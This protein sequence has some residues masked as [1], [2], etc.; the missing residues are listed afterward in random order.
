MSNRGNQM[1]Q[2]THLEIEVIKW[3][4]WLARK[5]FM[6]GKDICKDYWSV[7]DDKEWVCSNCENQVT[8]IF[9]SYMT[10]DKHDIW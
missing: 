7:K 10:C 8:K 4:Y 6:V 2:L 9:P 5:S 1:I 3:S